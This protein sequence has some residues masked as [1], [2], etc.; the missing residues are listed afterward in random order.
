MPLVDARYYKALLISPSKM[1]GAEI[2]PLLAYGLPLAP[3]HEVNGYPNRRQLV[4]VLKS[5]E[6]KLCFLDFSTEVQAFDFL[7]ELRS[8][9]PA[10]PVV[11]LLSSNKPD[12]VL[13]CMRQGATDFL[14]RP[15]TT[16]QVDACV[17][18]IARIIP[19]P[20]RN[21]SGSKAIAVMPAKGAS[22]ATTIA[23]NLAYQ[24]KRL[25]ASRV[26]LADL[27]PLTG[28]VAFV[29]KLKSTYSFVDVLHREDSLEAD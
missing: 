18:K 17:E 29:L 5:V 21:P 10:L 2:T 24:C 26:L 6:P 22:G 4:D 3:I 13:Q 15:F 11:A 9:E 8:V 19:A 20:S 27:D 14:I 23:C 12:L 7:R 1:I 25:G 28:T 16:D